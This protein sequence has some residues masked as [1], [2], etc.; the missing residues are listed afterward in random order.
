M[1]LVKSPSFE[2]SFTK[3]AI[4]R[5][6]GTHLC[7]LKMEEAAGIVGE[8]FPVGSFLPDPTDVELPLP[9]TADRC[10]G[11]TDKGFKMGSRCRTG[12][13]PTPRRVGCAVAKPA[14]LLSRRKLQ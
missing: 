11:A 7:T 5:T 6:L 8:P 1:N 12:G 10:K 14:R 2:F 3:M 4:F 9:V 13:N